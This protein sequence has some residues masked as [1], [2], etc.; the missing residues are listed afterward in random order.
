MER[1][2]AVKADVGPF[3][4]VVVPNRDRRLRPAVFPH[5][6]DPDKTYS[7]AEAVDILGVFTGRWRDAGLRP[8]AAAEPYAE[9]VLLPGVSRPPDRFTLWNVAPWALLWE[10]VADADEDEDQPPVPAW[11]ARAA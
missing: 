11:A 10:G 5:P 7:F 9:E 3:F 4:R 2:H 8:A 6:S 1:P